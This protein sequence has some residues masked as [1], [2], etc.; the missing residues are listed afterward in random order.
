MNRPAL[1]KHRVLVIDDNVAIH[2]DFR[3]ILSPAAIAPDLDAE[4]EAFFGEPV[5]PGPESAGAIF[6]LEFALQ[7]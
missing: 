5:P 1:P 6:E 3:R 4:A 7:G 2:E